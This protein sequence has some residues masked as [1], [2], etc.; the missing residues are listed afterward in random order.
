MTGLERDD[1][2]V[3]SFVAVAFTGEAVAIQGKVAMPLRS[4]GCGQPSR[5]SSEFS[6]S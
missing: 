6:W 2:V 1:D 5:G 4:W 3:L